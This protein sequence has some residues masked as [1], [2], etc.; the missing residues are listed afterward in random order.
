MDESGVI[1]VMFHVK[2]NKIGE[3][4]CCNYVLVLP[5]IAGL[6]VDWVP[7]GDFSAAL[8]HHLGRSCESE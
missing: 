5:R 8:G 4:L 6:S 3:A 2:H 7:S 1:R